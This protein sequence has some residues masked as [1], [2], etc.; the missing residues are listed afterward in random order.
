MQPA[1]RR[2][3]RIASCVQRAVAGGVR[4]RAVWES[5]QLQVSRVKRVHYGHCQSFFSS[6]VLSFRLKAPGQLIDVCTV[7]IF[8]SVC[9]ELCWRAGSTRIALIVGHGTIAVVAARGAH[10]RVDGG[11]SHRVI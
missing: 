5:P 1:H 6:S 4:R 7:G 10:R 3:A 11:V 8:T 9:G 2:R